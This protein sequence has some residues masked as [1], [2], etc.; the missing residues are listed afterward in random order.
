MIIMKSGLSGAGAYLDDMMAKNRPQQEL[1]EHVVAL[2]QHIQEYGFHIRTEKCTSFAL[3]NKYLGC[4]VDEIGH[5]QDPEN[6]G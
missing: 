3:S 5:R 6:F 1:Q 4:I 2:L